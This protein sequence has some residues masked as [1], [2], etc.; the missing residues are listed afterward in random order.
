MANL[1]VSSAQRQDTMQNQPIKILKRPSND[2]KTIAQTNT[3]QT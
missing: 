1:N 3:T 2:N